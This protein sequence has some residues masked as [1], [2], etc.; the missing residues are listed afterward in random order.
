MK[1]KRASL[2]EIRRQGLQA[3]HERL[4]LAGM[5]RFL[6]LYNP[7]SGDYTREKQLRADDETIEEIMARIEKRRAEERPIKSRK[8][9]TSAS[10]APRRKTKKQT[11]IS[12]AK[13]SPKA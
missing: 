2:E 10:P 7:G 9:P 1:Q 5:S 3:L 11:S 4:G 6:R 8:R 13:S 12:A